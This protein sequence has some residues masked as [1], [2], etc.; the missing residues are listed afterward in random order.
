[1]GLIQEY[2]NFQTPSEKINSIRKPLS[3][4]LKMDE[5]EMGRDVQNLR[6]HNTIS[7]DIC[8]IL[9]I[10]GLNRGL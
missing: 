2:I 1:M 6:S 10:N 7:V 8:H 5:M 4:V 3:R 9:D